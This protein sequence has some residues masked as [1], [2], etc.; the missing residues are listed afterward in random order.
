MRY[1]REVELGLNS[2]ARPK[3]SESPLVVVPADQ[4]LEFEIKSL[5]ISLLYLDDIYQPRSG[6]NTDV[7]NRY[8]DIL[9]DEIL[10]NGKSECPPV[11]VFVFPSSEGGD[12]YHLVHGHHRYAA[13]KK[14]QAGEIPCKIYRGSKD[15]AIRLAMQ[16]NI[17]NGLQ[18]TRK[19]VAIACRRYLAVND[20]L[21][22]NQRES[23]RAIARRFLV[24]PKSI[25]NY[26]AILDAEIKASRWQPGQMLL[27]AGWQDSDPSLVP[28][29]LCTFNGADEMGDGSYQASVSFEWPILFKS[30]WYPVQKLFEVPGD[31][32]ILSQ[33]DVAV[34]EIAFSRL[35]GYGIVVAAIYDDDGED[36]YCDFF[37]WHYGLN[38]CWAGALIALSSYQA[39]HLCSDIALAHT[40][41]YR[42]TAIE[43]IEFLISFYQ[44]QIENDV[45]P[46]LCQSK[47]LKCRKDLEFF[48]VISEGE[49][50]GESDFENESESDRS[51]S[52]KDETSIENSRWWE[53]FKDCS[54]DELKEAKKDIDRMIRALQ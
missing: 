9:A 34:G 7:V 16:A 33:P 4:N 37:S 43:R 23:D 35:Y 29:Y 54:L 3:K 17:F 38:K 24:D 53:I 49:S 36:Y 28:F 2:M 14:C 12:S 26:R 30:N 52:K 25:R 5:P 48:G 13:F 31:L 50:E 42:T 27:F 45:D 40:G 6:L 32:R 47:I 20:L 51:A 18:L 11:D 15:D 41:D 44:N 10:L 46:L 8:S 39:K 22:E 21:P 1:T 19:E